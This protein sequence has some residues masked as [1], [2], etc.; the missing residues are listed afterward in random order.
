MCNTKTGWLLG[1]ALLL[2][3]CASDMRADAVAPQRPECMVGGDAIG[4]TDSRTMM[5]SAR[6]RDCN[7]QP[8][9]DSD[10]GRMQVDFGKKK[11]G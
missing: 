11:D 6:D 8:S 1:A 4:T 9:R 2:G 5:P 7:P 10:K 3:G